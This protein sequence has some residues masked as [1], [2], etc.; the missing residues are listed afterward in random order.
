MIRGNDVSKLVELRTAGFI[1]DRSHFAEQRINAQL[2]AGHHFNYQNTELPSLVYM[3]RGGGTEV[4]IAVNYLAKYAR[5]KQ[6]RLTT[7]APM[8]RVVPKS[9]D[10]RVD[11]KS[12]EIAQLVW[13]DIVYRHQFRKLIKLWAYDYIVLGECIA[14]LSWDPDKGDLMQTETLSPEDDYGY[15]SED[16]D[17][18][19][20][21]EAG[22]MGGYGQPEELPESDSI[23]TFT[24]DLSIERVSPW[25]LIRPQ[26]CENINEAKWLCIDRFVHLKTVKNWMRNHP[27]KRKQIAPGDMA[28]S[29]EYMFDMSSGMRE[30]KDHVR[31]SE[32]YFRPCSEYPNGYYSFFTDNVVL[33]EGELPLGLFPIHYRGYLTAP[34]NPRHHSIIRDAKPIQAEINRCVGK[35]ITHSLTLGDDKVFL[36]TGSNIDEKQSEPGSRIIFYQPNPSGGSSGPTVI[37]GRTGIQHMDQA[38]RFVAMMQDIFDETD[39]AVIQGGSP[40]DAMK[41]DP[42]ALLHASYKEKEDNSF[43]GEE[44]EQFLVL[45]TQDVLHMA[46]GYYNDQQLLTALGLNEYAAVDDFRKNPLRDTVEIEPTSDSALSIIGRQH[47]FST[48]LQYVGARLPPKDI[49]LLLE[50]M[51]LGNKDLAFQ[52]LNQDHKIADNLIRNLDNGR[53]IKINPLGED[54]EF[55]IKSLISKIKEPGFIYKPWNVQQLYTQKLQEYQQIAAQQQQMMMELNKQ[56]IPTDGPLVKIGSMH[57]PNPNKSSSRTTIPARLPQAAIEWVIQRLEQQNMNQEKLM[58]LDMASQ[59]SVMQTAQ[60]MLGQGGGGPGGGQPQPMPQQ[61]P[62]QGMAG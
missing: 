43:Y 40:K 22:A 35:A 7:H 36:P 8:V 51:P 45:V 56:L 38:Q 58:G 4:E 53:D 31:V 5:I 46:R 57:V 11:R 50:G 61:M 16:K 24:G 18:S 2:V 17:G 10:E 44:F 14:R 15:G 29:S 60:Q 9:T 41:R 1:K 47:A 19:I 20:V 54:I 23:G 52:G 3:D 33:F 32:M 21:S 39:P 6:N 59:Q 12:A 28:E 30:V 25:N 13:E 55:M 26:E 49:G 37:E 34:G 48:A 42:M 27:E 62:P